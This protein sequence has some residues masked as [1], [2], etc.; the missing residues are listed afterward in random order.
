M[1]DDRIQELDACAIA[2][3]VVYGACWLAL[4]AWLAL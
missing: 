3:A 4:L 1:G 2:L